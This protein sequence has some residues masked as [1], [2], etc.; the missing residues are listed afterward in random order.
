MN[1]F[2]YSFIIRPARRETAFLHAVFFTYP[3]LAGRFL[4]CRRPT[5]STVLYLLFFPLLGVRNLA[6]GILC[7]FPFCPDIEYRLTLHD[8]HLSFGPD[9]ERAQMANAYENIE[10][11][12]RVGRLWCA[13][14]HDGYIVY[15]PPDEAG[16]LAAATIK[17]KQNAKQITATNT[18]ERR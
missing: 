5:A 11:L 3:R 10:A 4:F 7:T 1:D 6:N 18:G 14:L 12:F 16:D 13:L 9:N 2:S 8:G 17:G 15:L